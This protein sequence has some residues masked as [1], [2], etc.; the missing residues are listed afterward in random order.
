MTDT[1]ST[2]AKENTQP[3]PN[4]TPAPAPAEGSP[5]TP[6]V[7]ELV[8]AAKQEA[9]ANYDRYTRAVADMENLRKRTLREKEELRLYATSGLMED[10]VPILD[11]LGLGLGAAK[12]QSD[13]K[14]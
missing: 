13:V 6:K 1:T 5:A 14:S 10:I 8:A 7:D 4:P 9:A 3:T 12:Q 2:D 11:N